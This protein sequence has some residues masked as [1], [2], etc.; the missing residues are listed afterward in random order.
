MELN[1]ECNNIWWIGW[2]NFGA[3]ESSVQICR[4]LQDQLRPLHSSAGAFKLG[5]LFSQQCFLAFHNHKLFCLWYLCIIFLYHTC[6]LY[7]SIKFVYHLLL[8]YLSVWEWQDSWHHM[9]VHIQYRGLSLYIYMVNLATITTILQSEE[10]LEMPIQ[11]I[12]RWSLGLGCCQLRDTLWSCDQASLDIHLE[13]KIEWTLTCALRLWSNELDMHFK[14]TMV[15]TW[16]L[17]SGEFGD[18]VG[19]WDHVNCE[20]H[21]VVVMEQKWRHTAGWPIW[22]WYMRTEA[23]QVQEL[24]SFVNS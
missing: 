14:A 1:S 5:T 7:L 4:R 10:H 17:W 19:G 9:M 22:R 20:M 2:S 24:W 18:T 11:W 15:Q 16:R 21:L 3:A 6:L 13:V 23:G 8:S 12:S